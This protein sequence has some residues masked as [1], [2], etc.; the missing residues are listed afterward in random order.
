MVQRSK[1]CHKEVV[2]SSLQGAI[3][4]TIKDNTSDPLFI[5]F[6]IPDDMC[7]KTAPFSDLPVWAPTCIQSECQASGGGG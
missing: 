7:N 2:T 4:R 5:G 1:D 6:T 3:E